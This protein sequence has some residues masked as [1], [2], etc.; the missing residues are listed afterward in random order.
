MTTNIGDWKLTSIAPAIVSS[1]GA[2][3]I[4]GRELTG[5][6][7]LSYDDIM[8]HISANPL[9]NSYEMKKLSPITLAKAC[10]GKWS[11]LGTLEETTRSVDF[12]YATKRAYP[13]EITSGK[14]LIESQLD[15]I[16]WEVSLIR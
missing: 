15:S 12:G 16:P 1:T 6:F 10:Q 13:I 11:K 4:K 2:V 9:S 14:Q 5:D 7:A 3:A 8:A